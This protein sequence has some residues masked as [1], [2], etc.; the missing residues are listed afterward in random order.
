MDA[1]AEHGAGPEQSVFLIDFCVGLR[2]RKQLLDEGDFRE[3]LAKM[4][5]DVAFGMLPGE[6]TRRFELGVGR[7]RREARRDR[8]VEAALAA[9][10]LDQ[11]LGLVIAALRRVA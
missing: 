4:G 8:V 3:I 10:T 5:L 2:P 1:M 9:P 7:S 6:R 11:R